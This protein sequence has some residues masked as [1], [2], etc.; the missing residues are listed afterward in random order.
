MTEEIIII[1]PE[2]II[3]PK[4]VSTFGGKRSQLKNKSAKKVIPVNVIK[5]NN[6]TAIDD[7]ICS[8]NFFFI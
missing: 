8:I 1:N 2:I 6:I 3:N 5:N 7:V 4:N